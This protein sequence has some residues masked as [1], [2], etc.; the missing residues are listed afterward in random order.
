MSYENMT[1]MI[2]IMEHKITAS[3]IQPCECDLQ[4]YIIRKNDGGPINLC[5]KNIKKNKKVVIK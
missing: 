5:P 2:I 4:H 1:H 3:E